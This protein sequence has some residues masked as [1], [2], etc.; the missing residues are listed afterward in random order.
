[1]NRVHD[2]V[3][4][5]SPSGRGAKSEGPAQGS[6]R[7][8]N[9]AGMAECSGQAGVTLIELV[10]AIVIIGIALAGV[11]L[12]LNRAI[13]TSGDPVV[14]QQA[15]AIGEAYMEEISG[16]AYNREPNSGGRATFNDVSDYDGLEDQGAKDQ[17][18]TPIS[19]LENYRIAV[20]VA[21]ATLKGAQAKLITVTVSHPGI[22]NIVLQTYR[23]DLS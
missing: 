1:M 22:Q 3:L 17:T 19:G 23:L 4:L 7:R 15:I 10:I 5:L 20:S 2:I 8:V 12:A 16:K 9:S 14:Q 13:A 6:A 18:G 11:L 21:P